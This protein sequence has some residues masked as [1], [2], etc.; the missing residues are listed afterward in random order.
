M[1]DFDS[2]QMRALAS[3]RILARISNSTKIPIGIPA[4]LRIVGRIPAIIMASLGLRRELQPVSG[5]RRVLGLCNELM[6][7]QLLPP[8]SRPS[9]VPGADLGGALCAL[10]RG[11]S[12]R[13]FALGVDWRL[14][15]PRNS[16]VGRSLAGS[17][18][19][20]IQYLL[21]THYLYVG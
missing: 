2:P 1:G 9:Q 15:P 12:A 3:D 14:S 18:E 4:G 21:A 20:S 19:F 7:V 6:G 17:L 13:P 8:R 10:L 11:C 16:G 5:S